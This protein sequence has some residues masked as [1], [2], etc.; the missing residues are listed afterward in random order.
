M[1][2]QQSHG[3]PFAYL[4][5]LEV[6]LGDHI[7]AI[8]PDPLGSIVVAKAMRDMIIVGIII[9]VI[10]WWVKAVNIC[11]SGHSYRIGI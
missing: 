9:I 8:E 5:F 7:V 1:L 11:Q 4:F 10:E 3:L 6:D 2:L